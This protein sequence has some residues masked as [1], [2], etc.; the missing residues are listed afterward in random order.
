MNTAKNDVLLSYD[1]NIVIQLG[2]LAFGGGGKQKFGGGGGGFFL[3][4]E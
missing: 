1:L 4:G 3:V 2:K